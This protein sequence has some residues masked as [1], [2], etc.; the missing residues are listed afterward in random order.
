MKKVFI[1]TE[2]KE[3]KY[4]VKFSLIVEGGGRGIVHEL[5]FYSTY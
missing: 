2:D 4:T 3:V 5:M 1:G